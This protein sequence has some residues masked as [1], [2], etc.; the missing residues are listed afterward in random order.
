MWSH[1]PPPAA[2]PA[3][4]CSMWFAMNCP[5]HDTWAFER[6]ATEFFMSATDDLHNN[7]HTS[8]RAC[9]M[10]EETPPGGERPRN[11]MDHS[12]NYKTRSHPGGAS[13]LL[14]RRRR[15]TTKTPYKRDTLLRPVLLKQQRQAARGQLREKNTVGHA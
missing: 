2:G 8:R 10:A 1:R 11:E 12:S 15:R 4:N 5:A 7:T 6:S 9:G 3:T 13:K 14:R